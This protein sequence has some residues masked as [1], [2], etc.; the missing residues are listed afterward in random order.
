[1]PDGC[2]RLV[3]NARGWIMTWVPN[4]SFQDT[5]VIFLIVRVR[6]FGIL[7]YLKI[8]KLRYACLA[9]DSHLL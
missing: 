9:I 3:L 8:A 5:K 1:M 4:S 7:V 6:L 2:K